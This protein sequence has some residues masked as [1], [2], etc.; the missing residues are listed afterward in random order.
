MMLAQASNSLG[1][2][3]EETGFAA[4][5]I[6]AVLI[7]AGVIVRFCSDM[8]WIGAGKRKTKAQKRTG[9][10]KFMTHGEHAV[11]MTAYGA[12][13]DLKLTKQ[14]VEVRDML[15][16]RIKPVTEKLNDMAE[17]V[18]TLVGRKQCK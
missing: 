2:T 7:V 6:V 8:G 1:M 10:D 5:I 17:D 15:D 14:S 18:A 16:E 4:I 12:T 9:M 11:A 3:R 13:M